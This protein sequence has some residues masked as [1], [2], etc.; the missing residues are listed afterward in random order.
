MNKYTINQLIE[1]YPLLKPCEDNIAKAYSLLKDCFL[2]GNKLLIAGNG[3]SCSDS[4]H[5]VGELMKGFKKSR[6]I[7]QDLA[8]NLLKID[9]KQ[10]H[11]L[12]ERL[13]Q[14]LPAISLSGHQSLNT[15]IINDIDNGG[16]FIFAQQVLSYG[17][18]DDVLLAIST[19]GNAKNIYN[20]CLVAKAKKMKVIL[21]SG[22]DG[23]I[24]NNIADCSIIV[25]NN[26]TY[27]IQEYHLPIY[28]CLCLMLEETFFED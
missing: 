24:I 19:S 2:N 28:H 27:I 8:Q 18:K 3:G 10:G 15:A 20:A 4:E 1:R 14:G 16:Q 25:P 12:I 22:K 7:D 26:E 9:E 5:I 13:Q 6:K 21:L 17:I 11:I 23:G